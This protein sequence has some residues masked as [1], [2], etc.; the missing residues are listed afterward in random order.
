M[1]QSGLAAA[2]GIG[3]V[4]EVRI[5]NGDQSPRCDTLAAIA[6]A[7]GRPIADF[8]DGGLVR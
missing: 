7:L 1:T 2:A 4:T 6:H 8:L 5:E 3:R